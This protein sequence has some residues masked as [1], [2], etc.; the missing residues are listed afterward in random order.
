[1]AFLKW[2]R[3]AG[4][5]AI[6]VAGTF[7]SGCQQERDVLDIEAPGVDID[8]D[9]SSEGVDVDISSDAASE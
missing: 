5:L 6:L 9:E 3:T 7:T 8:V 4:I 2:G 1:M